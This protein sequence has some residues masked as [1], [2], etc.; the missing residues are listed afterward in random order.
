MPRVPALVNCK[1]VAFDKNGPSAVR[2]I[3]IAEAW[4]RLGAIVCLRKE[5]DIGTDLA[6]AGQLGVGIPGG[7][8]NIGHA[9]N[10]AL[11]TDPSNT[12]VVSFDW[13]N[14]FNTPSRR[15]AL[16]AEVAATYPSLLPFVNL[17][18]GAHTTVRFF[19]HHPSGPIDVTS[20]S[21][22]RQ[23]GPLGSA[24]FS[25]MGKSTLQAVKTAHPHVH[26][27]AYTDDTYLMGPPDDMTGAFHTLIQAGASIHLQPSLHKCHVYGTPG[28]RVVVG[29]NCCSRKVQRLVVGPCIAYCLCSRVASVDVVVP[30]PAILCFAPLSIVTALLHHC[31]H[32]LQNNSPTSAVC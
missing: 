14:A 23:G 19:A 22:V 11:A 18:Y 10:A 27:I 26:P 15:T 12:L 16:F 1:G 30:A 31:K 21:G 24:L 13:A 25:L 17:R 29:R 20:A 7:A 5:P 6:E 3:A 4:L 2:P 28:F 9:I 32:T 8:D